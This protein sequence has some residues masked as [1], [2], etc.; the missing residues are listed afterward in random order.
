ME[1]LDDKIMESFYKKAVYLLEETINYC[2]SDLTIGERTL[3]ITTL[4]EHKK[5]ELRDM[6]ATMAS[7]GSYMVAKHMMVTMMMTSR[8]G[9]EIDLRN[10]ISL[11]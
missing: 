11:N 1:N 10:D 6:A 8:L 9:E 2:Y 7:G 4:K 3:L 5:A